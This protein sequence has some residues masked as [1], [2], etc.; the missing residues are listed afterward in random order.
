[1]SR[2]DFALCYGIAKVYFMS[3]LFI[4]LY[5]Y[6]FSSY[7]RIFWVGFYLEP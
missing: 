5:E 7:G 4:Y 6:N 2:S 3:F 1:M